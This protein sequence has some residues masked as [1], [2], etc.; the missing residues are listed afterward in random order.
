M[1][2]SIDARRISHERLGDEIIIVNVTS[3]AYYAGVGTAADVWTLISQGASSEEAATRLASVYGCDGQI[4]S[5]QVKACLDLLVE[6][7]VLQPDAGHG[8]VSAAL[9]LPDVPR[10]PWATPLFQEY[11]DMWDLIQLDPIHDVGD[12]GW[13][14]AAPPPRT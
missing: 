1:H 8:R 10:A 6:R 11:L 13:P 3:G 5:E 2:Y 12:A 9:A 4:A 14:F 7:G